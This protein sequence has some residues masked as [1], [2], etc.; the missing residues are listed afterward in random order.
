[1]SHRST[2]TRIEKRCTSRPCAMRWRCSSLKSGI[3]GQTGGG[4]GRLWCPV[5]GGHLR[6]KATPTRSF[7]CNYECCSSTLKATAPSG[8]AIDKSG[9]KRAAD[10]PGLNANG[11]GSRGRTCVSNNACSYSSFN[12]SRPK[13][14]ADVMSFGVFQQWPRPTGPIARK[15]PTAKTALRPISKTLK[16]TAQDA[17][18]I[19]ILSSPEKHGKFKH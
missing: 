18:S 2:G 7:R 5:A 13:M 16:T 1:M 9:G 17:L 15:T 10:S 6:D 4:D 14:V 11:R 8:N 3:W 19:Q 12:C